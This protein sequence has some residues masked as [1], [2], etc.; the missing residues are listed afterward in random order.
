MHGLSSP[1][2][3]TGLAQVQVGTGTA[4]GSDPVALIRSIPR[5]ER[6]QLR[7][8]TARAQQPQGC[9]QELQKF[10]AS[11]VSLFFSDGNEPLD[12]LTGDPA[13]PGV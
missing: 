9:K 8:F 6:Q 10:T 7:S 13:R 5:Q 11:F 1:C 3:E 2:C 4:G 12:L